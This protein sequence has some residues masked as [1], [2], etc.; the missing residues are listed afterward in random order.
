MN[1]METHLNYEEQL[2]KFISQGMI[3]KDKKKALERIKHISYYKIKEFSSFFMNPNGT[4]KKDTYFEAIIQNFY[5]D[6]NLRMEFLKCSEKIELSIKNKIVYTLG[7]KY[8]AFGYLKFSNWCD[9]KISKENIL[10]EEEKFRKKIKQKMKLFSS[11]P[12]IKDFIKNNPDE[13]FPS[14]WRIAEILTFGEIL[15]LFE[16]MSQKNKISVVRNYGLEIDEFTSYM[17]NMKLIRNLCAHNMAII[18]IKLKS[19]PKIN[20]KISELIT[21]PDKILTSILIMAYLIK[22]INPNYRFYDLYHILNQ[23]IKRDDVARKYGIKKK[24]MVAKF[25]GIKFKK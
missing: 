12:I 14:V 17:N 6:K 13:E 20:S 5:F 16:I 4:Y 23:L 3:I 9:R 8:G 11:N 15:R 22:I 19:I 21:S 1:C 2:E 10:K 24:K 18:N 25:L 7:A